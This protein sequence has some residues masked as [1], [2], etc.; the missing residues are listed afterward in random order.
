M[1]KS[2]VKRFNNVI[3]GLCDIY[4]K[5]ATPFLLKAYFETLKDLT[6]EEV[7]VA[8]VKYMRLPEK[9]C[10]FMPKPGNLREMIF[11]N[12]ND[13][14]ALAW[15]KVIKTVRQYGAYRSIA[16]DDPLI[17]RVIHSMDGWPAICKTTNDELPFVEARFCKHY[18]SLRHT[19][20]PFEYPAYLV[21]ITEQENARKG[22]SA[23]PIIMI[24]DKEQ[25]KKV[26]SYAGRQEVT[27][28][29]RK[30]SRPFEG[31]L[32]HNDVPFVGYESPKRIGVN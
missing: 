22:Y 23:D 25:V 4:G 24:G 10:R 26:M 17:H 13:A 5:E 19:Q 6:I 27:P 14:A 11:G 20:E 2:D 16:F 21:G 1:L 28:Q 18:V 3:T 31:A 29:L 30:L 12:S 7:E 8:A 15:Q 32:I 9:E